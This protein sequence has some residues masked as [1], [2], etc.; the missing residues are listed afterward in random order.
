[1]DLSAL[2]TDMHSHLIAG[3]DDGA[4]DEEDSTIILMTCSNQTRRC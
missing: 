4:E 1:V 2:G 3:I